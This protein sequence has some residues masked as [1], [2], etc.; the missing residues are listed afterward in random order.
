MSLKKAI[1]VRMPA[2][3]Q[4]WLVENAMKS[5]KIFN[6]PVFDMLLR[7]F[8]FYGGNIDEIKET[9][10]KISPSRSMKKVFDDAGSKKIQLGDKYFTDNDYPK[11][12]QAYF[13]AVTYFFLLEYFTDELDESRRNYDKYMPVYEKFCKLITPKIN[14]IEFPYKNGAIK[15]QYRVPEGDGPFPAIIFLQ[16]NEGSKEHMVSFENYALKRGMATLSVDPPGYG[17]TRF[18]GITWETEEDFKTCIHKVVDFLYEQDVIKNSGIGIFGVSGG[19][20]TSPYAASFEKRIAA[21]AGL[22][23][24]SVYTFVKAWKYALVSQKRKTFRYSGTSNLKDCEAW[25]SRLQKD[26][27]K[28]LKRIDVP[29]LWVNGTDD[30]LV[31]IQDIRMLTEALGSKSEFLP[32]T[33]GDHLC[34]QY[35]QH[36]LAGK[37]FDWFFEQLSSM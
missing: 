29:N 3:I 37:I 15:A 24:T 7:T 2:F 14:R 17:E 19:G 33:G 11:A 16:G 30:R 35:L 23:G 22:G 1:I 5:G 27:L 6:T 21:S 28:S 8:E 12:Q 36:G 18:T 9:L 4:D 26:V 13:D 34:S 32:V 25:M 31:D 20:L 10:K